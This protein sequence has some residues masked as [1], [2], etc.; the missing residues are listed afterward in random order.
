MSWVFISVL[1][2]TVLQFIL[3]HGLRWLFISVILTLIARIMFM[4]RAIGAIVKVKNICILEG[5]SV[6]IL[7]LINILS[8]HQTD[9]LKLLL[10]I[11]FTGLCCLIMFIDD[12][13]FLY[14][15]EDEES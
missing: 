13:L 3:C 11:I 7:V 14:V 4:G 2:L 1:L 10:F 15:T 5:F 6:G 9:W 8:K 12:A